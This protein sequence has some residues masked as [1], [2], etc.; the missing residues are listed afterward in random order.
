MTTGPSVFGTTWRRSTCRRRDAERLRRLHIFLPFDRERLAAHDARHVEPQHRADGDEHQDEVSPEED[1]EQDDEEDEGQR[2]EDVD[3]AHHDLVDLAAEIAGGGA[4]D[5]AD[6]DRDE[7]GKQ[8]DG[9][10][11]ASGDQ[12][13]GQ[14]IA[15]GIVRSEE[16]V[17][18]LDRRGHRGIDSLSGAIASMRR[19]LEQAGAVEVADDALVDLALARHLDDDARALLSPGLRDRRAPRRKAHSQRT[20]DL[21]VRR[22]GGEARRNPH[23]VAVD[24]REGVPG[25]ERPDDAEQRH[26]D[27]VD[28]ADDRRL[29]RPQPPPGIAPE[30]AAGDTGSGADGRVS[31]SAPAGRSPRR[32][33]RRSG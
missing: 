23:I 30:R 31:H 24:R 29:V 6:D 1:D 18:P 5:H 25:E 11:H 14:E 10:R 4:V 7:A 13:A 33:G 16:E 26:R 32:A 28:G 3:D 21:L 22:I 12:G 8:A 20:L 19:V 17:V 2:I 15:A 9:E 27:E